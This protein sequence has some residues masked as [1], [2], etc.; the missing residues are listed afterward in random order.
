MAYRLG[1]RPNRARGDGRPALAPE[2]GPRG[3]VE[4]GLLLQQE[5]IQQF[6]LAA[7]R[8]FLEARRCC[9]VSPMAHAE[10]RALS[11][12]LKSIIK[13]SNYVNSVLLTGCGNSD[14]LLY[15]AAV[16]I[17]SGVATLAAR[18]WRQTLEAGDTKWAQVADLANMALSPDQILES[19][20]PGNRGR[21]ALMFADRLYASR[22]DHAIRGKFL[23]VAAAR[24]P[25]DLDRPVAEPLW[26]QG[27]AWSE[28]DVREPALR[29]MQEA[30]TL[31]GSR[32]EWRK[33]LIDRLIPGATL[34]RLINKL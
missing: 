13:P 30:L 29:H 10:L 23:S 12:L 26:L 9:L 19:V 3:K 25:S 32:F 11:C 6:L 18:C 7:A 34:K 15:A 24:L 5:P 33:D 21:N 1:S 17:Q 14:L 2:A 4:T 28:L 20:I 22:D 8:N 31:E 27:R 16:D